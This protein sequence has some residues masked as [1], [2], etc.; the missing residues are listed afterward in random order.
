MEYKIPFGGKWHTFTDEDLRTMDKQKAELWRYEYEKYDKNRISYF[1]AHGQGLDFLNDRESDICIL[2]A[3]NRQGKTFHSCAWM[4][5][6]AVPC[7]PEWHCFKYHGLDWHEHEGEFECYMGS[8]SWSTV[9]KALWPTFGE[10]MPM[11]VLKEWHPLYYGKGKKRIKGGGTTSIPLDFG[12]YRRVRLDFACYTQGQTSVESMAYKYALSDEQM[13]RDM[14]DG[15]IERGRTEGGIKIAVAVTPHVVKGRP[16]TGMNGWVYAASTGHDTLG[17]NIKFY[18]ITIDDVP[19]EIISADE[20]QAAYTKHI[21]IPSRNKDYKKMREGRSRLYGEF[22][23]GEGR[24]LEEWDPRIHI[25]EP[26]DLPDDVSRYRAMDHG[27]KGTTACLWAAVMRNGD[28]ILYREYYEKGMNIGQNAKRI[29]EL[30]GSER[31]HVSNLTSLDGMV[32][33]V[34]REVFGKEK[35]VAS[36][37]DPRSFNARSQSGLNIGPM[38]NNFGLQCGPATTQ[39][40]ITLLPIM[41]QWLAERDPEKFPHPHVEGRGAPRLYVFN[42]LR[43]FIREAGMWCVSEKTGNPGKENDHIAGSCFKYL[44]GCN[45]QYYGKRY[46]SDISASIRNGSGNPS[47]S[48]SLSSRKKNPITGY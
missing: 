23:G 20:K 41:N 33:P 31:I 35:Y 3:G 9:E 47:K 8:Y 34:M 45:P 24:C 38:Y 32:W 6:R 27:G 26:F 30:S 22:E 2:T 28:M 10:L 43:N 29:S 48:G 44:V 4:V 13:P 16:D 42:T 36:V 7:D 19:D 46:L 18:K 12:N 21:V 37:L 17:K 11:D 1:L 25:I 15:L 40:T 39:H 5:L 14:V